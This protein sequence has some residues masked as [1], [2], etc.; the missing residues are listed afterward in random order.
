MNSFQ[1]YDI[2]M[3]I[4]EDMPVYNGKKE[5]LPKIIVER[6]FSSGS[7]Y[8]SRVE[9]NMHTGTHLDRSLHMIPGGTK[10]ES[11]RLEQVITKCR[12]LDLSS[13][14]DKI[15]AEDL[16]DKNITEGDFI[17]LKTRNSFEDILEGK[18]IYVDASGAEYLMEKKIEGVGIDSLGIE[19]NQP[20]HPTHIRLLEADIVILEGLRLKE[21]EE[22]EY[23]LFAA[24]INI[25]EAEAAPVRAVLLR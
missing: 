20:E 5:K 22:G 11:L 13:C 3:K 23:F 2:S 18:F 24:P 19:R 12:V 16:N 7:A 6:D 9:M 17:L 15:T 21:I 25:A 4:T 1:I 10:V 8:E 14:V